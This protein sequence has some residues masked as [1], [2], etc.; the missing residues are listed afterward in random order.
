MMNSDW[1]FIDRRGQ[2]VIPNEWDAT[3]G[4]DAS[5]LA[6]VARNGQWGAIDTTGKLV[7]PLHFD[8]ISGFDA[9]G[10]A[11]VSMGRSSGFIN[12]KGKIVIPLRYQ[13]VE[14]FDSTG[15]SRVEQNSRAGWIDR[16]GNI[17]VPIMYNGIKPQWF[18]TDHPRLLPVKIGTRSGLIDRNG[19]WV[20]PLGNGTIHLTKDPISPEREW[21]VRTPYPDDPFNMKPL[22]TPACYDDNGRLIWSGDGWWGVWQWRPDRQRSLA[23]AAG[24]FSLWGFIS[25]SCHRKKRKANA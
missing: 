24:I 2:T 16:E 4:F 6:C 5:G 21:Y 15:M 13:H 19:K 8:S 11:S 12:T 23:I 22:F 20:V 3:Q 1:G 17:K 7:I 9:K 25:L 10:M 18:F 14:P